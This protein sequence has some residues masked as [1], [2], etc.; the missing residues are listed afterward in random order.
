MSMFVADFE[1][2]KENNSTWVWAWG[3]CEIGNIDNF[4]YGSTLD[5]FMEWC[6]KGKINKTVYF[7]NLRFDG[8]FIFHWLL[9]NGFTYDPGKKREKT[10]SCLISGQGA[11][12]S[13]EILFKKM[14]KKVKKITILD[15]MKKLPF[16]VA[17]VAK[18]FGLS[19]TKGDIDHDVIRYP[20]HVIT[21]DELDYLKRDVQIIAMA[22]GVQMEQ[23]LDRMTIGGDS[24]KDFKAGLAGG[25]L[26]KGKKIF[27]RY[28]PTLPL[29]IDTQIRGSYKGGYTYVNPKYA[30][31][32]IGS[33]MVFDINSMYPWAMRYK[34]LPYSMPLPF[35]GKYMQDEQYPLYVQ[36]LYCEFTLKPKHLPTI[37][38]KNNLRYKATAYQSS[39]V[40]GMGNDEPV[41]LTLTNVD[42]ELFFE[43]YDVNVIEWLDGFMFKS[44]NGMFN[45]YI[46]YWMGVKIQAEIDENESMRTLAKLM[47][48]NL[49]GKFGSNPDVT[50]R[51]PVLN[52]DGSISYEENNE[53]FS[54]P[55]YTAM[56]AFITSYCRDNI[57]RAAQSVYDR[58]IYADTDSLHL[59]GTDMP[60][61]DIHKTRLGAWKHESTF[62]RARFL[63]AKAYIEEIDGHLHAK[64]AGMPDNLKNY[65]TWDNF[66]FYNEDMQLPARDGYWFGKLTPRHVTGGQ[67]L[68]PTS[69]KLTE[70][71]VG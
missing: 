9:E 47:L 59:V 60:D 18:G 53:E 38:I 70:K 16:S 29:H 1:T 28:F 56:A 39:H 36:R 50:G 68:E 15:S 57:I 27:E 30:G 17:R 32:N 67:I 19:M 11:F 63:R 12:Y 24:M 20:G 4:Q 21:P 65:V 26:K 48:N 7:H 51:H 43:H 5:S 35:K 42:L 61:L 6:K 8:E 69:Y 55:V 41:E 10:F 66:Q 54:D 37:Q 25:D 46:D 31:Q 2:S 23:D 44:C 64:C 34:D 14:N 13:I 33:G 22:L 45:R 49:Y 52:D 40:D 3:F 62:T 58:F 71:F